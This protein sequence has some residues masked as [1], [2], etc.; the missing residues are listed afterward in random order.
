MLSYCCFSLF[1][2]SRRCALLLALANA[3]SN[4]DARIAI[5]A[6]TTSNS[7]SVNPQSL[8]SLG[9]WEVCF[10]ER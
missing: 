2:Q 8:P 4:S 10:H 1:K 9:R 7:I 6:M 5:M 3:G